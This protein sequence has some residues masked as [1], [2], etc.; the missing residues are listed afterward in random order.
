MHHSDFMKIFLYGLKTWLTFDLDNTYANAGLKFMAK[1]ATTQALDIND[2]ENE[3]E[4]SETEI[5]SVFHECFE[6]L[7]K[8]TSSKN[9]IRLRI[10][11]FVNMLL[12]SMGRNA[13]L[14]EDICIQIQEYMTGSLKDSNNSVR[15]E[16]VRALQR[17]QDPTDTECPVIQMYIYHLQTDPVAKVRQAVLTVLCRTKCTLPHIIERLWDIDESVR[18][19]CII[20]M[21]AYNVKL[22]TIQQRIDF[23]AQG[24]YDRSTSVRQV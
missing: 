5:Q 23:L 16:G 4:N 19:H 22:Y 7:L 18:R 15:V 17:L 12:D 13:E 9:V 21:S 8:H 14:D 3:T 2:Q 10:C 6:F 24:L 11:Q 20:Q 1:Y